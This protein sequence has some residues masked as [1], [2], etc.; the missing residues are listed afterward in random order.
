[1][2]GGGSILEVDSFSK[3]PREKRNEISKIAT[4]ASE[5]LGRR[6]PKSI[7]RKICV[8]FPLNVI[9]LNEIPRDRGFRFQ[10]NRT[11]ATETGSFDAANDLQSHAR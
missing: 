9:P 6:G 2:G 5:I 3:F 11:I 8:V 7:S 10:G 4:H 1:M